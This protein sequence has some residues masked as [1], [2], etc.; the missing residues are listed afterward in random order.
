[1]TDPVIEVSTDR[2]RL[3]LGFIHA[4]LV[5][6]HWAKDIPCATLARAVDNSVP[7]GLYKDGR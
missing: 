6:S 1:M 2:S 5:A 4:F 7:F 3:D